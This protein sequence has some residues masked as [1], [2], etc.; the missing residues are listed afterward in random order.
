[1]VIKGNRALMKTAVLFPG[2]SLAKGLGT[3]SLSVGARQP[4]FL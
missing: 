2:L 3:Q 4:A 1:M